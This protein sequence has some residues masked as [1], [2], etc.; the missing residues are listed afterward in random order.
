MIKPDYDDG[1][2][3]VKINMIPRQSTANRAF[4]HMMAGQ[5]S[6]MEGVPQNPSTGIDE[7]F[8]YDYWYCPA[9]FYTEFVGKNPEWNEDYIRGEC[10]AL[11]RHMVHLM[12]MD[13]TIIE[14]KPF[15][16]LICI[17]NLQHYY[18]DIIRKDRE[19]I[20]ELED[21]IKNMQTAIAEEE[22]SI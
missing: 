9:A 6:P 2:H 7:F 3:A 19:Y 15:S 17:E 20:K 5:E 8:I 18:N 1:E 16:V 11:K 21:K 4:L 22:H 12:M 14:I 13:R 10:G